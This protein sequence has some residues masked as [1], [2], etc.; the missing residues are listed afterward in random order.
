MRVFYDNTKGIELTTNTFEPIAIGFELIFMCFIYDCS[1]K[2]MSVTIT[3]HNRA[4]LCSYSIVLSR[5][6]V[7]NHVS[8]ATRS[9]QNHSIKNRLEISKLYPKTL[10]Y[11][12]RTTFSTDIPILYKNKR[13]LFIVPR[14]LVNLSEVLAAHLL[15]S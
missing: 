7:I 15:S 13:S 1:C 14:H 12:L 3:L 5:R 10:M 2:C 4:I 6:D 9:P 11:L 8:G